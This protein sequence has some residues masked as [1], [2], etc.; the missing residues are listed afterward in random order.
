MM[1]PLIHPPSLVHLVVLFL[2]PHCR[3]PLYD[4]I[5][6][7]ATI[8]QPQLPLAAT[9]AITT[10][11]LSLI[12]ACCQSKLFPECPCSPLHR[13][14]AHPIPYPTP[15]NPRK[16]VLAHDHQA[17]DQ[18]EEVQEDSTKAVARRESLIH[19]HLI[20]FS[21]PMIIAHWR[22]SESVLQQPR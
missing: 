18:R 10:P 4:M 9:A 17:M 20:A 6:L 22:K 2:Q 16:T 15:S 13:P 14:Q 7:L 8:C 5:Q 1:S 11:L 3:H 19:C 21:H 12:P